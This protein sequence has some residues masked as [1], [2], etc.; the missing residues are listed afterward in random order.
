MSNNTQIVISEAL[1][2]KIKT[3]ADKCINR[4][5]TIDKGITEIE[6][7][8]DAYNEHFHTGRG[9]VIKAGGVDDL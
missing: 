5:I 1:M 7:T 3:V 6:F 8:V 2:L 4:E 9:K